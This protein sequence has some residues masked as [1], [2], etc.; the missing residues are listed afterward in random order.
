[1]QAGLESDRLPGSIASEYEK[2][3]I[4]TEKVYVF[5]F[6]KLLLELLTCKRT[7]DFGPLVNVFS[8][9]LHKKHMYGP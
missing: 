2:T 6:G 5:S 3:G 8:S 4:A 1:M 7:L 9:R